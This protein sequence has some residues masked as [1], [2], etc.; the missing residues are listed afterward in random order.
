ML[1]DSS[2]PLFVLLSLPSQA[3]PRLQKNIPHSS[4][5]CEDSITLLEENLSWSV[6]FWIYSV[7]EVVQQ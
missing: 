1:G 2:G 7:P 5:L 6:Y 4:A 3:P